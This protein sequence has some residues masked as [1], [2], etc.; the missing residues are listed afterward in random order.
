MMVS[1]S[2]CAGFQRRR[3]RASFDKAVSEAGSPDLRSAMTEGM[4]QPVMRRAAS[5]LTVRIRSFFE[6]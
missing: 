2:D 1:I 6:M 5:R 4:G 3:S